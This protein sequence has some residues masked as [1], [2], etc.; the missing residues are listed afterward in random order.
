MVLGALNILATSSGHRPQV[1]HM[2]ASLDRSSIV[3]SDAASLTTASHATDRSCCANA[4]PSVLGG[5]F[6]SADKGR[7]NPY[8]RNTGNTGCASHSQLAGI[9][10]P[11]C[12][13]GCEAAVGVGFLPRASRRNLI[14]EN[15]CR[16]APLSAVRPVALSLRTRFEP[17]RNPPSA[18]GYRV[19]NRQENLRV[20]LHVSAPFRQAV[21]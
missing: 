4:T 6:R 21:L 16:R 8:S 3:A 10:A 2:A 14:K 9:I 11:P 13:V 19:L 1:R 12:P 5:F 20:R 7:G 17:R 18:G 15:G